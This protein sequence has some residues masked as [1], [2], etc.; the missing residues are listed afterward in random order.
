[1]LILPYTS[2]TNSTGK[3]DSTCTYRRVSK[4]QVDTAYKMD[5]LL[6]KPIKGQKEA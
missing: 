1:M 2:S 5:R 4:Y 6:N 3:Q